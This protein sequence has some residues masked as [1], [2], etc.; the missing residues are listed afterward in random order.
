LIG[1]HRSLVD[2]ARRAILAGDTNKQIARDLR[3][4]AKRAMASLEQGLA[5]YGIDVA[6]A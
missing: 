5:D 2:Y 3:H 4:Q 1:L 6:R